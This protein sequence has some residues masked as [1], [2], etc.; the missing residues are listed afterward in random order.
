MLV[1]PVFAISSCRRVF[2]RFLMRVTRQTDLAGGIGLGWAGAAGSTQ[3]L[4]YEEGVGIKSL[5][6]FYFGRFGRGSKVEGSLSHDLNRSDVL[7]ARVLIDV[8]AV[9]EVV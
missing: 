6:A 1:T 3:R 5:F 8:K 2:T 7:D 9:K 4:Y